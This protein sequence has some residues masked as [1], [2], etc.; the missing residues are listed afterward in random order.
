[1]SQ[2]GV[3][4]FGQKNPSATAAPDKANTPE[5]PKSR[6]SL[7]IMQLEPRIMF[8]GAAA[9]SVDHH[10][11]SA[12]ASDG[13]AASAAHGADH[14]ADNGAKS[15]PAATAPNQTNAPGP[16]DEKTTPPTDA[17]H[18]EPAATPTAHEVVFIDSRVPDLQSLIAGVAPGT[19]VHVL[20]AGRDGV[21]QIADYLAEHH[22]TDLSAIQI[23][24]HG[25]QGAV[26]LGSTELNTAN[27]ADHAAALADI[28][29]A[30]SADGDIA[31]YGCDVASQQ[32]QQFIA[33]LSGYT[34]ADIAASTDATGHTALGGNWTLEATTGAIEAATPFSAAATASYQHVLADTL[35]TT[36]VTILTGDTDG[37]GVVDPNE[38][39]TTTVTITNNSTTTAAINVQLNETLDR[40]TLVPGSVKITPIAFN[41]SGAAFTLTGN[42][43]VTYTAAQL[44]ANDVDP[45]GLQTNLVIDSVSNAQHGSVSLLAGVV[46]FTPDAGYEGT[47][48]FQYTIKDSQNLLSVSTGV[49]T[50]TVTDPV[51]YV[52]STYNGSNGVSDGTYLRPYLSLTPL[53]NDGVDLDDVGETIF[54]YDR[55]AA[56]YNAGIVLEAGQ[57]LFGDGHAFVVN[58]LT[59][60]A[61]ASNSII[62]NAAIGVT[63][64]TNNTIDGLTINGTA[65]T[66]IGIE[67][68]NGTVGNLTITNTS[69]TGSGKA[70]DIDQG[71]NLNVNLTLLNSANSTTEGVDLQGVS[72]TF[73]VGTGNGSITGSAGTAFNVVGGNANISYGGSIFQS[74]AGQRII[75]VRDTTGGSVVFNDGVANALVDS[76]AG[77]L[78]DGAA[79]NVTIN[80]ADLNGTRGIEILGDAA[81]NATG[82]FTFNNVT[83][84]TLAGVTNHALIVDGDQGNTANNDVSATVALNNVDITNPGGL[85]ASIAGMAAGSVTFDTASAIARSNQGLGISVSSNAGGTVT[86]GGTTK[87]LNTGAN[88]AVSL[89]NNTGA[90]INFTGGGLDIDTTSGTG[91]LANG[92]GI[93]S[94]QGSG[95]SI[96][97]TTGTAL[98]LSGVTIGTNGVTFAPVST[99]GAASG[100]L[101]DTVAQQAGSSGV[102]ILGGSIVNASVRGVDINAT[103][104]DVSI[105]ASISSTAAGRSVEVTNSGSGAVGGNQFVFGGLITDPGL[106]INLDNN[107]QSGNGAT[108]SF[109]GG[110]N[111]NS[112]VNRGFTAT[113]GGTIVVTGSTNT[114][115]ST[116]GTA[117]QVVNTI[118]GANDLTFRS[119]SSNGGTDTGIILDNTGSAGGLHVPGSGGPGSGGTIANKTGADGSTSTGIG[120][121]LNNTFDVQLDRMQLNGFQNY[122]IRGLGVNNFSLSNSVVNGVNGNNVG[123]DEGAVIF[124]N[125]NGTTGLSGTATI[126]GVTISGGAEDNLG[127]YN[128]SGTLNLTVTS[129][130]IT[131]AGNDGISVELHSAGTTNVS[132]QSS[133]FTDNI[134]DHF[135][136][137][138]N[139][140]ANL[141]V[142]FGNTSGNVLNTTGP[143]Y[144]AVLGGSLAVQTGQLWSGTG[145]ADISN[146]TITFAKD[147]PINVNIGGTGTFGATIQNNTIGANGVL[148]SGTSGNK[149]AIRLVANGDKGALGAGANGGTFNALVTGNT[150]QQVSGRGIFAIGRD[151]GS[152]ADPIQL[153][154]TIQ[155][156]L[157]RQ[158]S[159]SSGQAIRVESG[160]SSSPTPDH[161]TVNANIGGAGALANNFSDDWGPAGF[162]EI[163]ILNT[164][165]GGNR[166]ILT[167]YAGGLTDDTAA[168]AYLTARNTFAVPDPSNVTVSRSATNSW[169]GSGSPPPLPLLAAPGGVEAAPPAETPQPTDTPPAST[170]PAT[171]GD[172]TASPADPA[173]T[174]TAE[175]PT[176][177]TADAAPVVDDGLL[178]QA[179]LDAMVDAAMQRWAEA[180]LTADQLAA[181]RELHFTV[182]DMTG[183]YLGSYQPNL[184]TLDVDAAGHGWYVDTTPLNDS[185]FGHTIA[186]TQLQTD[187]T[188]AP[189]G[190]FDL[191]T[192]VMHEMGHALGLGDSYSLDARANL[193]YG[194]LVLGER[195]LAS[196][197][198]AD[199]A[200]AGSITG[201]EFLGAPVAATIATLPA[202]KAVQVIWQATIDPQTNQ[203]IVNPV[204][205]G[206]VTSNNFGNYQTDSDT[207]LAGAQANTTVLDTLT[208][209]NKIWN[210]VN[211]N[212]VDDGETG[213]AGVNVTLFADT[214]DDNVPDNIG[215]PLATTTTN[216][217][218]NYS[219]AG[220]APGNYIVRVDAGNFLVGG[221]LASFTDTSAAFA[222]PDNNADGDD[223]GGPLAGGV[224][225]TQAITLDYGSEVSPDA[226]AR[227]DI[228][229]TLDIG[230]ITNVKPDL[231][232]VSG[233]AFYTE[234]AA[235][236]VL[237]SALT[238]TD[239]NDANLASATIKIN[240][241]VAG[242][243]LSANVGA[244]GIVATY[245]GA[246][247]LTL[248]GSFSKAAYE[249]VLRTVAYSSTSD[250]PTVVNTD[251][252]RN[253]SWQVN[254]GQPSNNLSDPETTVVSLTAVNDAP[255]L[256]AAASPVLATINEDAGAPVGAVGTLV[257]GLVDFAGGGGND[258]VSDPDGTTTIGIALTSANTANGTWYYSTNG[259]TTWTDVNQTGA[260][261]DGNALL[262]LANAQTRLYFQAN[263]DFNGGSDISFR[264]WDRSN[265]DA[266]A[267]T[268]V[269]VTSN[270]G[271]TPYSTASDTA[272][273][274][275]N[276]VADA[277]NDALVVGEDAG[278]S[279][280][281]VLANDNFENAGRTLT[282]VT[283]GTNGTVAFLAD[284]TVTYTANADFNGTDSFTYTVTSGGVTETATVNVTVNAVGDIVNDSATT[285][286]DTAVTTNV[287]G[288]DSF[289]NTAAVTGV[290][291]GVHG[292]V[293]NNGDGTVTYTPNADF[294][295]VDSYSYTVTSGGVT[296]TATVT[297][298]VNAVADI[299]N[300]TATTNEDTAVT[301]NVLTNDNFE[302][303]PV[304]TAV[305]QGTH[306]TVVNN[307]N[308]T[309]TYTPTAD[310]NGTDSYSYTVTSGGVTE[311]TTVGV[312][313]NPVVDIVADTLTTNEDTAITANVITGTNG[314]S[315]D[316]FEDGGRTLTS[317]T[318]GT[319]GSVTFLADGTVTYTPDADY[320]GTDS[321][322][323]TVTSGGGLTETATVTVTI[324]PVADIAN[325]VATTAEETAV[326]TNVLNNDNF[327]ATPVVTGVTNGAN[328]TVTNNNNGTVT[329]M[330]NADFNGTDIYTYTVTSGGVTETATV[331][332]TVTATAD[333]TADT[334]TTSEDNSVTAN[335][336][337]GTNGANVDTFEN[338]DRAI[339]SVTQGANGT[340]TFLADG[341]VT[342]TPAADFNGT[343]SFSYTVTSGGVTETATV[344]VNVSADGDIVADTLAT[345]ED[346]AVTA[347]VITG[348]N[349]ASAD[350]FEG[351][352]AISSVTQGASGSVSFLADGT[353][354]YTP[355]ADFH[356]T[357]TFTYTVT[358]GGVTETT[359]VTVNVSAV[360]DIVADTLTTSEDNAVTAN[361][362]TG[363]NGA[364]ADNFEDAGRT[365]T[366]VTQGANGSVT[367]LADG[368]VTYT[369]NA[370]FNGTDTYTYTVTS[371]GGLTETATV[372][373]NVSAVGDIVADTLTTSEDN[374]VTANLITGTNGAS[375][376]NFEDAGRALTSV[377]QGT[378]GSVTFLANGTVTY[379]ANADF[380]GTDTFTYTVTSGAGQTETATVTVNVA[381]VADIVADTLTT[382]EDTAIT[383]NVITGTNGASTDS[384]E[385]GTR[386]LTSVTQGANGSVTFLANGTVTYTPNLNYNG[387][388]TF[389]YTVTSGGVTETATV[390]VNIAPVNDPAIISGTSTGTVVEAGGVANGTTNTPT[391]S[392][393]LTDTD[394]DNPPNTFQSAAAG[395]ATS[396]G[397]GTYQMTAG[398]TW[399]YTLNNNNATVQALNVGGT[400]T[401]S[402]TV[403]TQ[404]GTSKVVNITING[405]NDNAVVAG[406][407]TNAGDPVIEA[408]GVNNGRG[409]DPFALGTL[410]STDIDNAG[411]TFQIAAGAST[412]GYGAY[413]ILANGLWGYALNNSNATVQALKPGNTLIDTFV[414]HTQ[415]GTAQTVT[416]TINGDNDAP[417]VESHNTIS[418]NANNGG[419]VLVNPNVDLSD[420]DS[421]VITGATVAITSGRD[422]GDVLQFVNQ[423]G[424]TGSFN[425]GTGVLTLTGNASV[426]TYETAMK[427]V[428]FAS[429]SGD[430]G[431]R[432][433]TWRATDGLDNSGPDTT[434]IQV[435]G[436]DT[437][438]HRSN[439]GY[440]AGNSGNGGNNGNS[441]SNGLITNVSTNERWN[442]NI[443]SGYFYINADIRRVGLDGSV[444]ELQTPVASLAD[445]LGGDAVLTTATLLDGKPLPE[446]L[447]FDPQTGIL[448]GK[449]PVNIVASIQPNVGQATDDVVTGAIGNGGD[450]T[451]P[452]THN[453]ISIQITSRDAQGNIAT[454]IFT[455]D[456]TS[457][458]SWLPPTGRD[459]RHHAAIELQRALAGSSVAPTAFMAPAL[460]GLND[461]LAEASDGAGRIGLSQQLDGHGWRG[462]HA[463]RMALIASLQQSAAGWR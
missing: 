62:N 200:A 65:N 280:I 359:T 171:T 403:L 7:G 93:V 372:T 414:V 190:H 16:S 426:A 58:G 95:N 377:T 141:N 148:N 53:S 113:N 393:T 207:G 211:G 427:T 246:G 269:D 283:Q 139:D 214:N 463:D 98:N 39:V 275:V 31:L 140:A 132:V 371:G 124:G 354:T 345:S 77:I 114:I 128:T 297:V 12:P 168:D 456:L 350:N 276:A 295:G 205:Q 356:G 409:N 369:P 410:T 292:T 192:T 314:A 63:L 320:N 404:D 138:A 202:G 35:T 117:L 316:N 230:F 201:E 270:G 254:D 243:V 418:Y 149:D 444:L 364:S 442:G 78:V 142:Q 147:T 421:T 321:F 51:W 341:T 431:P 54:V 455:I 72:G 249:Q 358:S 59:I 134:G 79:G 288:N 453:M 87:T 99:N 38:T 300:D 22:L 402:F 90:T 43:P 257:S 67:D 347:N 131:G 380:N 339:T 325:D 256:N 28:G 218:G 406:N 346:N 180:G 379:T 216:G 64:A 212:G 118:I 317:V 259:G 184:I 224:V 182:A 135:N 365:L 460:D 370:D 439:D 291:Q 446:W 179:E 107:D 318:Q 172:Q 66:A 18:T 1:M 146:N 27:L 129:T 348:T 443:G 85:V 195:R 334:L 360:D 395:S 116:T 381:A 76:G 245:D 48:S 167:G 425:A 247:T 121:Y 306:G 97:T 170:E 71:G 189:A 32:G 331:T 417:V 260:I 165:P 386:T 217:S 45:D 309:V 174:Q 374:A 223:N 312:T 422:N 330:P 110:L 225:Y 389:T 74:A 229:N 450:G 185:E 424:I 133:A 115:T 209:G 319:N 176:A 445:A 428:R 338:I 454:T 240:D 248:T 322:S 109:S 150:I 4:R 105:S 11:S 91:F 415:D 143:A 385:N 34:G 344:T 14:A 311:T 56:A 227:L 41:D 130:T 361:V 30:L 231:A 333:I 416:I 394:V 336:I 127:V 296:E 451:P 278:P 305:T 163:R 175:T 429:T 232:A 355:N 155:S 158:S 52:D 92:G 103:S 219:F 96:T 101:M 419:S 430:S 46:T 187:P 449:L 173:P 391:A 400:L 407:T 274:A 408:G 279:T 104:A 61:T 375:A 152:A 47:A 266:N 44:L 263:A 106:G 397:Y 329:Y 37:D 383:A 448:A 199:G 215:A 86:F 3:G 238:V 144:A 242:D 23:V 437:H 272:G 367:F 281:N 100:V 398:G 273:I 73:T 434:I 244:T 239:G 178:S 313:V 452:A 203:L 285:N 21:Q 151:G 413:G 89:S 352:A 351:S 26:H 382:N 440:Y 290:T 392:G 19:D 458:Q 289:E 441:S 161:V 432:T 235:P 177:P 286:E 412:N 315:A 36:Q 194:Y 258:N 123:F 349:G 433:V 362:I 457:K 154:L 197:G 220:L 159:A 343:D 298:T 206:T 42:T 237:S 287:L 302:G 310:F 373:V 164:I 70:I 68:G 357:D 436:V 328:G 401:D 102:D 112:T 388:D 119:I 111:I 81:N 233:V 160:A 252:S 447:K 75:S 282:S 335:L 399:T 122:A 60:G 405:A 94:V 384:F 157:F 376:D 390:T 15:A 308:G 84:H 396:N 57:T 25:S 29:A 303:S 265:G 183:W 188:G 324:S 82:T 268:K 24:S 327:E 40:M 208:L 196:D 5:K 353:V 307:N 378:N 438:H 368:T 83:I 2:F 145:S 226:T 411:G 340:V 156:N 69:L 186:A 162:S 261:A 33:A 88:T 8:D 236:T 284:G 293:V 461:A 221:A 210:D 459:T 277:V 366:A 10:D 294:N 267:G 153:N 55:G 191:L 299:A 13:A 363:T 323:Y 264:A 234:N 342:Y 166:F 250:N 337:L 125:R 423:N 50:L 387:L 228:N 137:V 9:A 108:I 301:T 222:D 169:E 80:N 126:T 193:M 120:I 20:D 262:L 271:T 253:V 213:I 435:R 136:A 49:V 204:N 255:V 326:T 462:M 6:R 241:F 181:L 304:V 198:Q 332:V 251:N 17:S 420:V